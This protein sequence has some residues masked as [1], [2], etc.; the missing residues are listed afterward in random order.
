MVKNLPAV[1]E[2]QVRSLGWEEPLERKWLPSPVFMPGESH[3][4]RS[5]V[6][7]SS[8]GCKEWDMT[9]WL[10]LSLFTIMS[11]HWAGYRGYTEEDNIGLCLPGSPDGDYHEKGSRD[12]PSGLVVKNLP[13]NSGDIGLIP[14]QTCKILDA[15]GQLSVCTTTTEILSSGAPV[16]QIEGCSCIAVKDPLCCN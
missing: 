4:Q 7:Y 3:G 1:Q 6:G 10:T 16:P 8:W 9:E 12:F 15:L 14:G 11:Q 13:S 2:T 5:L